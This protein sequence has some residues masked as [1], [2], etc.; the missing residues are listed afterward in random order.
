[1]KKMKLFLAL[2]LFGFM[3]YT[4]AQQKPLNWVHISSKDGG[5]EAP[6]GGIQQTSTAV[7]D[8]DNDGINDFCV[9]ERTQTPSIVWYRRT[10]KGW[11][12]Y[13]VEDS[14]MSPE[15]G[16]VAFDVDGDGDL[17]IIA[18]G[19]GGKTKEVYWWENPY[20]NFDPK[21]PWK[22]HMIYKGGGKYHDQIV[23]DFDGDGKP[24]LA[25]WSQTE[26]ELIWARIPDNP[27]DFS[28]WKCIP[29]YKY[30]DDGQ[31][32]QRGR[33]PD[34]KGVNEHEGLAKLDIDGDGIEDIIGGGCWFKYIG[35]DKF[36]CNVVDDSYTFSRSAAG[37]L[38]KGGRPE[39]V[40]VV[41]DGWAPLELYEYQDKGKGDKTWVPKTIIDT[42]SNGHT[43]QLVDFDGDGN[44]DIW[45]AEMTLGGNTHALD[46]ILLG[47][48]KGNFPREI[49]VSRG[50]D[51][52]ES[53]MADLDGDGD[54]DILD[55]PYNGDTPRLDIWL[56][57]GTGEVVSARKGSFNIPYGLEIYSLRFE[58]KKDVPKTIALMKQMGFKDLEVSGYYGLTPKA[59]KDEISKNGLTCSSM[60]FDYNR[61]QTDIGGIIKEA[62]LF[63]AKYAGVGWI[64]HT[65]GPFNMA[66]AKKACKDF[67]DF[68]AK[69]KK[70]GLK[71]FYHPHGYEFNT[72]DG[73]LMDLILEQTKP[74]LVTFE[75]DVF[76][77]THGGADPLA[78]LKKYPGRFEL[79]HLKE[80]N[81]DVPGNNTGS[82]PDETSVSLG[83]GV[84]DW[85]RL[86]RLAQ[87]MGTKKYYI[88]DEAKNAADQVPFS[89][90]Y[91]ETLK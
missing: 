8:F 43:L 73:N 58:L 4:Q 79:M 31:M 3:G 47:D 56:Q 68:G 55:K 51:V 5:I 35:N 62:K 59:F 75:L 26:H 34:F 37:Q 24:D 6:N 82:A 80:I 52:H 29:I 27:K 86:L 78:Y 23:G 25:F 64:P 20:P 87:K 44:L 7:G 84:T 22:R 74:Q 42:V 54:L 12:K 61:F 53:E 32:Q 72:A 76:W 16:T 65:A 49:V 2:C 18:G 71:F 77:A 19:D 14:A 88:E 30:Y 48:G 11:D 57:N 91:L 46:H 66:D 38:I 89:I 50:I 39:I 28:A 67:N 10:N 45:N 81:H 21:T 17:D 13:I 41:G 70:A 40:F 83:R 9:T 15:A 60:I 69:L 85:P 90:K 63:G 36:S 33:Y 1:M